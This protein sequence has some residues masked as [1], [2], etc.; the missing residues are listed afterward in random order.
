[1]A[2]GLCKSADSLI[3]FHVL[4][5]NLNRLEYIKLIEKGKVTMK[6]FINYM[7]LQV[8]KFTV[9]DFAFFKLALVSAGILLGSYFAAFFQAIILLIWILFVV[10]YF[11]VLYA[12][13]RTR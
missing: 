12:T 2:F 13:F 3:R 11:A 10:S 4:T 8:K 1:M 7:M 6:S 9:I 5:G